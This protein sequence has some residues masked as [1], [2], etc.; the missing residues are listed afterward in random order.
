MGAYV[1]STRKDAN[2]RILPDDVLVA[3]ADADVVGLVMDA[4]MPTLGEVRFVFPCTAPAH[5][6]I[7]SQGQVP[8]GFNGWAYANGSRISKAMFPDAYAALRGI[9]YAGKQDRGTDITLPRL[10][11]FVRI[12]SAGA[13]YS[14]APANCPCPPHRHRLSSSSSAASSPQIYRRCAYIWST[15]IDE[16]AAG[17]KMPAQASGF[18]AYGQTFQEGV[19]ESLAAH[20]GSEK[21]HKYVK[22]DV[23]IDSDT[24]AGATVGL[25]CETGQASSQAGVWPEHVA[26][27]AQIYI[28]LPEGA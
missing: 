28:G 3:A 19:P 22:W 14:D 13:A 21:V 1:G 15:G 20:C 7:L 27:S 4:V 26:A 11:R 25:D 5:G 10:E 17:G 12:Q 8:A 16:S 23:P 2:G 9:S 18:A 6:D 24:L